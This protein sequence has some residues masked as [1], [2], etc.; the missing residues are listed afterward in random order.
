MQLLCSVGG[1][2][3]EIAL[4]GVLLWRN[5]HRSN[6][7]FFLYIL[8]TCLH[9]IA[10]LALRREVALYFYI[11]YGGHV[12]QQ[13]L[14]VAIAAE[15]LLDSF[16]ALRIVP[17]GAA[18]TLAAAIVWVIFT[19]SLVAAGTGTAYTRRVAVLARSLDRS[20]TFILFATFLFIALFSSYLDVPWKR[21]AYGIGLG[22]LFS[23]PVQTVLTWLES[24]QKGAIN[25]HLWIIWVSTFFVTQSIWLATF[26]APESKRFRAS[27]A[28]LLRLEQE[29]REG[30]ITVEAVAPE[31]SLEGGSLEAHS[32][33]LRETKPASPLRQ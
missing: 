17:R 21:R 12:I 30:R 33:W 3:L 2:V 6:P 1:I 13:G 16:R 19:I 9:D 4:V 20:V 14:L 27:V 23:L 32:Y 10:L 26:L 31:A 5:A 7:A 24:L 29:I 11:Y 15:M 18:A 25:D 22:F 8:F 28:D